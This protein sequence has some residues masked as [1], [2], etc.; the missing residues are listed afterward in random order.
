M[1]HGQAVRRLNLLAESR[2]KLYDLA[3]VSFS[4]GDAS[5]YV[6]PRGITG[7]FHYGME[8]VPAGV[9]SHSWSVVGHHHCEAPTR[10][11]F[12]IHESGRAHVSHD[13]WSPRPPCRLPVAGPLKMGRLM[14]MRYFHIASLTMPSFRTLRLPERTLM[15]EGEVVDFA[16]PFG[17]SDQGVVALYVNAF[18]AAGSNPSAWF[19]LDRESLE[20]PL[21]LGI[22]GTPRAIPMAGE[23]QGLVMLAGWDERANDVTAEAASSTC[24][25]RSAIGGQEGAVSVPK[26]PHPTPTSA[27]RPQG[28]PRGHSRGPREGNPRPF[29]ESSEVRGQKGMSSPAAAR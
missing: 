28:V 13:M 27:A 8:T 17:E 20:R 19:E 12:S 9:R 4:K 29:Y 16:F 14:D 11:K 18:E 21:Y 24:A 25:R 3:E 5:I 1:P 23:N 22:V 7:T 26:S 2:G 10:V 15:S 6:R